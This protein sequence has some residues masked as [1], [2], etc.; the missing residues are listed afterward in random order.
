MNI[1]AFALLALSVSLTAQEPSVPKFKFDPDWP[2]PLPNKWK[3]GGVTGL[4]VDKD[5]NVWVLNRPNDLT[6]IELEAELTPPLADC[7]VRP[8]ADDPHRQERQRHR[9]LRCA[10]GPRHGGRQQR[11]RLHRTEYGP[12]IRSEDRQG[13]RR[14]ASHAR[15]AAGRRGRSRP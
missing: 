4:A 9:F 12:Q 5:D 10:P 3:M 14:G 6:D 15:E 8:P 7:C 2:K 13:G 1:R 11:V